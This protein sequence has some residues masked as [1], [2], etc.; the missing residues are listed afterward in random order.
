VV[1]TASDIV[2]K[3]EPENIPDVLRQ[4]ARW[5]VWK[6][7]QAKDGTFTKKPMQAS[8]PSRGM[9]KTTPS[10]WRPFATALKAYQGTSGIDGVGFVC[11][12]GFVALDFD[13]CVDEVTRELRPDVAEVLERLNTY[14]EYSPSGRGVRAFLLGT[15]PGEN[16]TSKAAGC[17]LYAEGAYVT[18]TGFRVPGTPAEVAEGG[19]LL[20]ELYANAKRAQADAGERRREERKAKKAST[21]E[22]AA[23]G[24]RQNGKQE[25]GRIQTRPE[26]SRQDVLEL[27]KA[28]ACGPAVESLMA[29][30]WQGDY[31]T[32]SE[33]ELALA[34]YLAFFA[35]PSGEA[36]VERIM[37]SS[38]LNRDKF[39]ESRGDNRTY[40]SLTVG[41]AYEGRTDFYSSTAGK[42]KAAAEV[43]LPNGMA[44]TGPADLND[45][46]TL[47][48]VGLARRLVLEASDTLRYVR[49]WKAWL[50]WT[51]RHWQKDDGLAAA[52]VA[53]QVSDK[54]WRELAELPPE[55]RGQV[56][57]FVKAAAS[58]RGIEA[59]VKL[60]RSE[61]QVVVTAD[62]LNRH[63]YLLNV[64]NGTLDLLTAE[65][66]PHSPAD[67]LTH[68]AGV[69]FDASASCPNW[70]KFVE[71]VTDGD[72]ELAAFLQ[73]SC[74]VAL[75]GD[76]T[77]QVL[78]LH[79][80]EGRNGKSTMLTM[81]V[82]LLGTYAGPAPLEMLLVR[83][84]FSKEVET[85]F[86]ALAGKRLVTAVEADD[87][88]RFSE[89]TV[90]LLT[91]GDVVLARSLYENP[92][93]L[94]P[95]WKLHVAANHKPL[96][97]GSDEGIWRRLMLCPWLRR[98]EGQAEDKRLKEKLQAERAGI[99]N[100]CLF[101]FTEWRRM[102][103][104]PPAT[105]LAATKE[106]RGENDTLGLWIS[107]CCTKS[108]E[109]C[110]EALALYASYRAWSERMGE[111]PLTGKAFG[112]RMEQLGFNSERPSAGAWRNKTIRHG[113]GLLDEHGREP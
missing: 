112:L 80:G 4:A 102:G 37:R 30:R 29:G 107:E 79:H 33:A 13:E 86:G 103:L 89:A 50:S 57:T 44:S 61:P 100:W 41:T 47:T 18:V 78:W 69:A 8:W 46:S 77:E 104:K 62:E 71:E 19:E 73:R 49:E 111:H 15:L 39:D 36:E 16:V 84:R 27:A 1:L 75:S 67:L 5:C 82:E 2:V 11:G 34:N 97:R 26:T 109:V 43:K 90:K 12:G 23:P 63:E 48:D 3:V 74:G 21:A 81:L 6:R 51:G 93:P 99:L 31:P 55:R 64:G 87:G 101:G 68:M 95:S 54:L 110:Q 113:I 38:G 32:Q 56:L 7:E 105:V 10:Q 35:G 70:R 40:L 52:H 28:S 14:A 60:A 83:G 85:Q 91:G 106:Y 59:A 9:S 45:S 65:L 108:P 42:K 66:R 58:A 72:K 88:V 92:W 76:V 22:T 25:A 24:L 94:R 96:V 20:A 98:F 53:K 17:E